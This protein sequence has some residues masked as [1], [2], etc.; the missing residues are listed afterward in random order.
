[1]AAFYSLERCFCSSVRPWKAAASFSSVALD[2][3]HTTVKTLGTK[4][5]L[6]MRMTSSLAPV[7]TVQL[8]HVA[9]NS[10]SVRCPWS[11]DSPGLGSVPQL[12]SN[13]RQLMFTRREVHSTPK[14]SQFNSS[15][16]EDN[17]FEK[18]SEQLHSTAV[19]S[20]LLTAVS[21]SPPPLPGKHPDRS[22]P[23]LP[24]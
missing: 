7:H 6:L 9:A 18:V 24:E 20:A 21:A 12:K 1:M 22:K 19:T 11:W 10:R 15:D 13:R 3:S 4:R 14:Q 2:L 23:H 16:S 5:P 17:R 8:V